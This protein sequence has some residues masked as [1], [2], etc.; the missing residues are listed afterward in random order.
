MSTVYGASCQ[1]APSHRTPSSVSVYVASAE[2]EGAARVL[3]ER[4]VGRAR[5]T[6]AT[7]ASAPWR[8]PS[9]D[10]DRTSKPV[11]STAGP[12]RPARSRPGPGPGRRTRAASRR[13]RRRRWG[14]RC[15]IGSAMNRPMSSARPVR[16]P[17][18]PRASRSM[19]GSGPIS[20]TMRSA[21]AT[22]H[23]ERQRAVPGAVGRRDDRGSVGDRRGQVVLADL[24]A[25]HAERGVPAVAGAQLVEGPQAGLQV[26]VAAGDAEREDERDAVLQGRP[27]VRLDVGRLVRRHLVARAQPVR[28]PVAAGALG[29]DDV[30]APLQRLGDLVL[31][32][33]RRARCG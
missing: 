33:G 32:V 3:L 2:V 16:T 6:C 24:G 20:A 4:R 14:C 21:S 26:H 11:S 18:T 10:G 31:D 13:A 15:S 30:D 28:A 22:S 25:D 27:H 1:T 17:S 5:R 8:R 29:D 12:D 19:I 9:A 23:G 7:P